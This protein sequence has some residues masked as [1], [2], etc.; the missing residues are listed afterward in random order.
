MVLLE[1]QPDESAQLKTAFAGDRQVTVAAQ[2]GYAGLKA[3]LPPKEK[4]GLVLID[5]PYESDREYPHIIEGLRMAQARWASGIFAMW[6]PIKSRPPV[7]RFHRTLVATGIPKILV[8]EFCPYPED[9]SFRLNGCGMAV[10]NPPWK[11]DEML[12]ALLPKLLDMLGQHPAGR[13]RVYWLMPE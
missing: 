9:S 8:I 12:Q 7:D 6:Y 4:R 10:V 3:L 11:L 5:P 13:T 2:D 1:L